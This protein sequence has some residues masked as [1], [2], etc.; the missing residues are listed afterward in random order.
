MKKKKKSIKR[1]IPTRYRKLYQGGGDPQM[2]FTQEVPEGGWMD[3]TGMSGTDPQ[4]GT[5]T[6]GNSFGSGAYSGLASAGAGA[7]DALTGSGA[8]P[9]EEKAGWTT[10]EDED[11]SKK[12]DRL[13]TSTK[14]LGGVGA[15]LMAIPT[16]FTQA[17]GLALTGISAITN[18]FG[19]K[20]GR[21]AFTQ[22]RDPIYSENPYGN[23]AQYG[24][25]I[26]QAQ[27]G[28]SVDPQNPKGYQYAG[29]A[30][31]GVMAIDA[32]TGQAGNPY[33]QQA[34]YTIDQDEEMS[35]QASR[36]NTSSNVL[37]GVGDGLMSI[38]TPYT[39]AIGGVLKGVGAI[40]GAVGKKKNR[41]SYSQTMDPIYTTNP[42]GNIAQHGT[43][44]T[45]FQKYLQEG[46]GYPW[47][48][49]RMATDTLIGMDPRNLQ[50]TYSRDFPKD[51][52]KKGDPNPRLG[53]S[54]NA[55]SG[56]FNDL[57]DAFTQTYGPPTA[58]YLNAALPARE[59]YKGIDDPGTPVAPEL[60]KTFR[61]KQSGGPLGPENVDPDS[62][63]MA[64]A[65]NHNNPD[66]NNFKKT[67]NGEIVELQSKEI[68]TPDWV[69]SGGDSERPPLGY[70]KKGEPTSNHKKVKVSF[71]DTVAKMK[72]TMKDKR[73]PFTKKTVMANVEGVKMDN[74]SVLPQAPQPMQA[75]YG[76]SIPKAQ[77]GIGMLDNYPTL[78]DYRTIQ[79]ESVMDHDMFP[80]DL[81]RPVFEQPSPLP[82]AA[83]DLFKLPKDTREW[84]PTGNDIE[85][86]EQRKYIADPEEKGGNNGGENNMNKNGWTAGTKM[87]LGSAGPSILYNA[88]Q[89]L[90]KLDPNKAIY[91]PQR[92]KGIGL[93]AGR[94]INMQ[95]IKNDINLQRNAYKRDVANSV[96]GNAIFNSRNLAG[97]SLAMNNLAKAEMQAQGMNNDYRMQEAQFRDTVGRQ[98]VSA[99]ILANDLNA[100]DEANKR[101]FMA[102]ALSQL[103]TVGNS[104]GQAMDQNLY[105]NQLSTVLNDLYRNFYMNAGKVTHRKQYEK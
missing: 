86:N 1:K 103:S 93:M 37:G 40:T 24:M 41:E 27:N 60:E 14:V 39:Q 7:V 18:A 17:A 15:G 90:R 57:G 43:P 9:H 74:Q 23:I 54:P 20:A 34:G 102:K 76:A 36:L 53:E 92:D 10:T 30:D 96:S 26:P 85:N 59:F 32:L 80:D 100:Q 31:A 99:E 51:G 77:T 52:I 19:K 75:Q 84:H 87:S 29:L 33:T 105:N 46:A 97:Y 3:T 68:S 56:R 12:A 94:N 50:A 70:D 73:D 83:Y 13:G 6:T 78:D 47:E 4:M 63:V 65:P 25:K 35:Q 5:G 98:D 45:P 82:F 44:L 89:G 71:S 95:P 104:T 58:E 66:S 61:I 48:E 88:W 69:F 2:S 42:Y 62:L 79:Q 72:Q 81:H 38:K 22:T 28:Y 91:N 11:M 8:N 16:P 55:R 49:P 101:A 21:E 64:N 67:P